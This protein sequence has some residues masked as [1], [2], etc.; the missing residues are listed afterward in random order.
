[1]IGRAESV[2]VLGPFG[3]RLSAADVDRS[4]PLWPDRAAI[5]SATMK[6][7]TVHVA[8]IVDTI[9]VGP[10]G[11]GH[12]AQSTVVRATKPG[13]ERDVQQRPETNDA[14]RN[15]RV[16]STFVVNRPKNEP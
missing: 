2:L 1:V 15:N 5:A 13:L 14:G 16:A 7:A 9:S 4:R 12:R 6:A 11:A 8:I 3:H 10:H